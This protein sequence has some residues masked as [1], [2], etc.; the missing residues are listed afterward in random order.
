M[1]KEKLF[2]IAFAD[3]AFKMEKLLQFV[4]FNKF[5]LVTK[6]TEANAVRAYSS[7]IK[8]QVFVALDLLVNSMFSLVIILFQLNFLQLPYKRKMLNSKGLDLSDLT[9]P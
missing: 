2:Q 1:N 6:L 9:W 4:D 7:P 8:L 5:P 3:G